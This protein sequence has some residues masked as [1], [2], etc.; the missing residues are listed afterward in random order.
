MWNST[1]KPGGG[2]LIFVSQKLFSTIIEKEKESSG[3]WRYTY[4]TILGNKN[5]KQY[6]TT[7]IDQKRKIQS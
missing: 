1:Y 6:Y 3:V 4:M 7:C 5:K 2:R